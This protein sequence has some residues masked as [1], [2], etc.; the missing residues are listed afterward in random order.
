MVSNLARSWILCA[1]LFSNSENGGV[2]FGL[3]IEKE[4][5]SSQTNPLLEVSNLSEY[6]NNGYRGNAEGM[7]PL[8][9][10]GGITLPT[11]APE[12]F[13]FLR[14]FFPVAHLFIGIVYLQRIRRKL[15]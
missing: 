9:G 1:G 14:V 11:R 4:K 3:R 10:G 2:D 7:L 5:A 13:L 6:S 15:F 12:V 8:A